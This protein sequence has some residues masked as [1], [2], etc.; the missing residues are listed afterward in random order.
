MATNEVK[1]TGRIKDKLEYMK[2]GKARDMSLTSKYPSIS[3]MILC[4]YGV[5]FEI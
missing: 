3:V 1:D 5:S 2:G 4:P